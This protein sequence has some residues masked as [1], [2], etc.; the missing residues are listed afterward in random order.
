MRLLI[1]GATGRT[2]RH[3]LDQARAL[4]HEVAAFARRPEVLAAYGSRLPVIQGDITDR[5][6]M[7]R[8][9]AGQE[10]VLSALGSRTLRPSTMLSTGIGYT[11]DAV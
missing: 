6:R 2:G 4:G 1:L 10:A 5:S 9:V 3:L 8:G 7:A 11:L